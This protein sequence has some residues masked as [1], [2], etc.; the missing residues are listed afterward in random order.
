MRVV[1]REKHEQILETLT[2]LPDHY[3]EILRVVQFEERSYDDAAEILGITAKNVSVR[4]VRA[5]RAFLEAFNDENRASS[6]Q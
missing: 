3:R 4:L 2:Q 5:R 1:R 6:W